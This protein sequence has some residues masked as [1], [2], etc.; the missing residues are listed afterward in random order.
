MKKLDRVGLECA[1]YRVIQDVKEKKEEAADLLRQLHEPGSRVEVQLK[2]GQV[3]WTK[4]TVVHRYAPD[5][6]YVS[7]QIDNAKPRSRQRFRD[8]YYTAVRPRVEA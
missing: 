5:P 1:I 8:V 7:V 2:Y 3:N 4:A 6:G